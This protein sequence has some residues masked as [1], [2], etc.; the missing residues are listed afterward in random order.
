M[1]FKG[2]RQAFPT[3]DTFRI[4]GREMEMERRKMSNFLLNK[5]VCRQPTSTSIQLESH[6]RS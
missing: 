4:K 2:E 6:S 5:N 1:A 3:V